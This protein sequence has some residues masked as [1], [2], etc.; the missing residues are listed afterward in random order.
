MHRLRIQSPCEECYDQVQRLVPWP[1]FSHLDQ[2]HAPS[3]I[4]RRWHM[5]RIEH[6]RSQYHLA[7]NQ[8][9][10]HTFFRFV[11]KEYR[12]DYILLG[13]TSTDGRASL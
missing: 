13:W 9:N 5:S 10:N 2:I 12:Y 3:L 6:I 7:Y 4:E 11:R 8:Q 1:P